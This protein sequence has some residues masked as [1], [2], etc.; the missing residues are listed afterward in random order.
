MSQCEVKDSEQK[1]NIHTRPLIK[2]DVAM[3]LE[4]SMLFRSQDKSRRNLSV[5]EDSFL[6]LERRCNMED[7]TLRLMNANETLLFDIEPPSALWNQTYTQSVD[8]E[9]FDKSLENHIEEDS[10]EILDVSESFEISPMMYIGLMRPSTIIEETSSQLES[11][12]KTD[13]S[14]MGSSSFYEAAS[15]NELIDN[16]SIENCDTKNGS[17]TKQIECKNSS[18]NTQTPERQRRGTFAFKREHYTFFPEENLTPINMNASSNERSIENGDQFNNT[19][20]RVDYLLERG[21]QMFEKTP[22]SSKRSDQSFLETPHFSCKRKRLLN[23]MASIQMLPLFKRAPFTEFST[24]INQ[25]NF[26]KF[27]NK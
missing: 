23:E 24:L 22:D 27:S 13:S 16:A 18:R 12:N 1:E 11:I 5:E 20:E 3:E 21:K 7:K 26:R 6:A 17:E 4:N 14:S 10:N 25:V 19:L 8:V 9:S 2:K 15:I